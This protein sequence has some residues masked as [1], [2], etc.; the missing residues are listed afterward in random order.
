MC[1][2][3]GT[4]L[5]HDFWNPLGPILSL[6]GERIIYDSAIHQN[7][8]VAEVINGTR[9]NWPVTVSAD[10]FCFWINKNLLPKGEN[11]EPK[12]AAKSYQIKRKTDSTSPKTEGKGHQNE[13]RTT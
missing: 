9:W 10:L 5:W 13:T 4:S 12:Q 2:G 11:P 1:N 7:A 8:R 6:F 3:V